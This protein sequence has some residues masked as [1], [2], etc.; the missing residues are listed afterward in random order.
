M[1]DFQEDIENLLKLIVEKRKAMNLSQ[2]EMAEKIGTNQNS[3]KNIETGQSKLPF[4]TLLKILDV[5]QI[6]IFNIKNK[7]SESEL[8]SIP[9]NEEFLQSYVNLSKD[10]EEF[11]AQ[12]TQIVNLLKELLKKS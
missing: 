6:D 2:R 4:E 5:L 10:V 1:K 3:Y 7:T 11:K 9:T 8:M 12:N